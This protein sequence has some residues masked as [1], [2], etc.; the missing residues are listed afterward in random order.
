MCDIA[1]IICHTCSHFI[2]S[3]M[4]STEAARMR[5]PYTVRGAPNHSNMH[6]RS[7]IIEIQFNVSL[8]VLWGPLTW[9]IQ[10]A[11]L[12]NINSINSVYAVCAAIIHGL[13]AKEAPSAHIY[14]PKCSNCERRFTPAPA[15]RAHLCVSAI[16][17]WFFRRGVHASAESGHRAAP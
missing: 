16:L 11:A 7:S 17:T 6:I 5:G 2:D 9:Y 8:N 15:K 3:F 12:C 4:E 10:I 13:T 1:T 14:P